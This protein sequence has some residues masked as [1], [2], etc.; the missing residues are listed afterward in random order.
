MNVVSKFLG[1]S[2]FVVGCA[3]SGGGRPSA[4]DV[5]RSRS[6]QFQGP[7]ARSVVS[8]PATI[9]AYSGFKGTRLFTIAALTGTDRDC[10]RARSAAARR[11]ARLEADRVV[12][13]NVPAGQVA[14]VENTSRGT[15][16][17]LWHQT[18]QPS[19]EGPMLATSSN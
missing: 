13:F 12:T 16:E 11:E 2:L 6:M 1:L 5:S 4:A 8:G 18:E 14:C 19:G 9:H 10:E 3:T 7:S 17:L 15:H